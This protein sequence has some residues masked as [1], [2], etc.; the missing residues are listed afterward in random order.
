M[1][2]DTILFDLDDTLLGN[3][4]DRFLPQYFSLLGEFARPLFDDSQQLLQELLVG[5]QAMIVN[6]DPALTN[7]EVFWQVFRERTGLEVEGTEAFFNRFYEE[8]FSELEAV[9]EQRPVAIDVVSACFEQG[10]Q[11][12]VATNPLFPRR[13]IEHRLAWAGL[14]ISEYEFALVTSYETMHAAK[15]QQA[16]Y[17]EILERIGADAASTLMVGDDWEN[18][19]EPAA[20]LGMSVYWIAPKEAEPQDPD[21]I[22]GQG[23]LDDFYQW[24]TARTEQGA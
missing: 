15:P 6:T 3:N 21:L 8:K 2:I 18:D 4:M 23:S 22:A 5:T 16:Y 12:A 14:P 1:K 24:W 13:A 7:R 17:R 19:V 9:T 11:V 20:A 10:L